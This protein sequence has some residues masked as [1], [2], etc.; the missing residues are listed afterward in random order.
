[1]DT[2]GN[3]ERQNADWFEASIAELEPAIAAK[4]AALLESLWLDTLRTQEGQE[5]CPT[6]RSTPRQRQLAESLTEHPTIRWLR[7]H[8]R[9][10]W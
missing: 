2:F 6:D 10:V 1:M 5:R 3:G 7:E 8:L 9:H 4:R